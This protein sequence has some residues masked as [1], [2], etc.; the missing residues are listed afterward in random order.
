MAPTKQQ[1]D[2]VRQLVSS[3]NL[4]GPIAN[5]EVRPFSPALTS[6]LIAIDISTELPGG[7]QMVRNFVAKVKME[8]EDQ[9]EWV[10]ADTQFY[11]EC[12]VYSEVIPF[13]LKM[14][15]SQGVSRIFPE[16]LYSSYTKVDPVVIIENLESKGF[17]MG[18]Y[19]A[20]DYEHCALTLRT[21]A[22]F[23]SF[24]IAIKRK[25][26]T[27]FKEK[28]AQLKDP[29]YADNTLIFRT[30]QMLTRVCVR[31]CINSFEMFYPEYSATY[32]V[33]LQ[34]L[35][36][37]LNESVGELF[38]SLVKAEEPFSVLCHGDF[39][40]N[41]ILFRY[42]DDAKPCEVKFIDFQIIRYASPAI[43]ISLLLFLN[44]TSEFRA[45]NEDKL[46]RIYHQTLLENTAT[47]LGC[48]TAE[49]LSE[50]SLDK[51][52]TDYARH[53]L[54]G[55]LISA[56]FSRFVFGSEEECDRFVETIDNGRCTEDDL[57]TLLPIGGEFVQRRICDMLKDIL[58]RGYFK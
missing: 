38:Q 34:K 50:M 47:F 48:T 43:D 6:S 1:L 31:G 53:A 33:E 46:L 58:I 25:E 8:N 4:H 10:D 9:S 3:L 49:L 16:C 29:R 27:L 57:E 23:H 5:C 54:H 24:S 11:N 2:H 37:L 39:N 36:K 26:P 41:N 20:M 30:I 12:K 17:K 18:D 7:K 22:Q 45:E 14:I 55:F 44:T 35:L 32:A 19:G 13:F 28:I 42:D 51:F 40:R 56:M 15:P 52:K 21:L